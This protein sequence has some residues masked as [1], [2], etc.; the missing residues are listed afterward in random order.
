M[1]SKTKRRSFEQ[2]ISMF[3][4]HSKKKQ[5]SLQRNGGGVHENGHDHNTGMRFKKLLK[6]QL[7]TLKSELT[8]CKD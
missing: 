7:L 4:D 6:Y 2:H 1:S 5:N 3:E 8:V